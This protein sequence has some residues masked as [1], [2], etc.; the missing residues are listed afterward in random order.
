VSAA[1][2]F[3]AIAFVATALPPRAATAQ[4]TLR[5]DRGVAI[6]LPASPRRIVSLLPSLTETICALGAC[7][8]LVGTDRFSNWPDS[9]A[10][11]PKLGGIEDAQ[12]ERVVA[13]KPDVVLAST[14]ARVTDRLESLG[15]KVISLESRD[16]ADVKRTLALLGQMLGEQKKAEQVWAELERDT[17]AAAARVP[18]ELRDKRVYF[19]V[20]ATPYAAGPDSFIGETLKR[21]GLAN[22]IP[23]ELGP[24]P[25]LNPE[26]VVKVQPDIVMAVKAGLA[27]MPKRPGW[28]TLRALREG[29]ACGFPG[30]TYE[31]IIRP[32]PRMGE[33]AAALADCL[34]SI[35]RPKGK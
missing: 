20:D 17:R 4:T 32:G 2:I 5:D 23:A 31:L 25:R 33:A 13:L 9:V 8:R 18:A 35:A 7:D 19:E 14:S 16:H 3:A 12:I 11:L 22:A 24:F 34:V 28:N 21:L 6:V 15:I 1:A 26:L 27:D 29:R 30:P 10:A